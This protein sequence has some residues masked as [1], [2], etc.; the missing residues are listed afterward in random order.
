MGHVIYKH[1]I[2]VDLKRVEAVFKWE[3]PTNVPEVCSYLDMVGY[4]K[5][6]VK[7]FRGG[8]YRKSDTLLKD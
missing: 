7:G 8:K 6:Y 5:R 4:Y 2:K 1:G 3:L